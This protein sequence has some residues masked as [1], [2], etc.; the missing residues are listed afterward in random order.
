[1]DYENAEIFLLHY[2]ESDGNPYKHDD[3]SIQ[4]SEIQKVTVAIRLPPHVRNKFSELSWNFYNLKATEPLIAW[5]YKDDALVDWQL[6]WTLN[7][8][9]SLYAPFTIF[10]TQNARWGWAADNDSTVRESD[11][12]NSSWIVLNFYTV[13]NPKRNNDDYP[14]I[15]SSKDNEIKGADFKTIF[16]DPATSDLQ[17]KFSLLN[18]VLWGGSIAA[19][20]PFLEYY[21][22]FEPKPGVPDAMLS[23]KYFT[24]KTEWNFWDYKVDTIIYK[25]TIVESILKSFTTIL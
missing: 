15:I 1:M 6:K 23:D 14:T 19:R 5:W 10:A 22:E 12:N 24:I 16:T 25:P 11:L 18:L 20:Y 3:V 4:K 8:D 2:D 17:L 7:Y 13:R 21:A 9:V